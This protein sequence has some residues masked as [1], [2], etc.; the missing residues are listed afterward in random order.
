MSED[1]E[2]RQAHASPPGAAGPTTTLPP[3]PQVPVLMRPRVPPK[4]AIV[5]LPGSVPPAAVTAGLITAV[6]LPDDPGVGW[7]VA[8]LA[9]A[10]AVY[11][12]DKRAR[13][14]AEPH[15][16]LVN[17]L[18]ALAALGLLA[19]GV[20]RASAWLNVLCVL[21]A[22]VA[23][24][25]AVVGKRTVNTI[26]YDVFA[27]PIE[28]LL[29]IPWIGRGLGKIAKKPEIRTRPRFLVPVLAS[30]GLLLV[31][32]PLLRGADA[33]FA[34]LV[35]A[36]IP[37]LNPETFVRWGF[38]FVVGAFAVI[39]ACYLLAAPPLPAED[40]APRKRLAHRLEWALPLGVLVLLFAS[41]VA[42]RLVVLFGGTEYVL[43]TS[44]L[45]AAEYARSGF[46]QLSAITVLTLLL[47]AAALRWAP[48]SSRPD[49][50][51][52]RGLLGVLSVL[53]LVLV[54]SAWSRMWTYQEAYGF[55][56][57]R[58]LVEVCELWIGLIFALILV[59][60]IPLRSAWLPR[61]AIGAAVAALLGLAVLDPERF[62][63]ERNIDRIAAG[64][65]LDTRYLSGFSA[66]VVPAVDR[67]PEPLRSCVLGPVVMGIPEDDWRGWNLS[68]AR[69]RQTPVATADGERC[70]Y[71]ARR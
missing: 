11:F 54:A 12:A 29:A 69:A 25:L 35:D 68:R 16:G 17:A 38:L 2:D 65:T 63:A 46:W 43:R 58:L 44:G 31:F 57:L 49:R 60:L 21:A 55:T 22:C 18:W 23:G 1:Q 42:V 64:K 10:M 67:L 32:V 14:A 70:P 62:I 24:S 36:V 71:P 50:A 47:V 34:N 45:T 8:G 15:F 5:P 27:V 26:I 40:D 39:G 61:A 20:F 56:V 66:D 48:K 9:F 6:A 33:A 37:E 52:Q 28:A 53:S 3:A 51:W 59:S 41:F 30:A 13:G 7:F 19:V 4:S